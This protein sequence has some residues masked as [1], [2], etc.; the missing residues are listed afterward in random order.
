MFLLPVEEMQRADWLI[1]SGTSKFVARQVVSLVWYGM[2][3]YGM[4]WYGMVWY[5]MVWYGMVWYGM[6]WY[7]M[8][9]YGM[10]WYGMVWYGKL[11]LNHRNTLAPTTHTWFPWRACFVQI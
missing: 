2:V 4:V 3:W 10:V 11:Y 9:W 5:G 7:G 6:V 1:G 8:V